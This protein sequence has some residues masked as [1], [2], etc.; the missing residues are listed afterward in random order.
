MLL[1]PSP[2]MLVLSL[3]LVRRQQTVLRASHTVTSSIQEMYDGLVRMAE[4]G[5]GVAWADLSS[6]SLHDV[7]VSSLSQSQQALFDS[8]LVHS[9][10]AHRGAAGSQRN[11]PSIASSLGI[12]S[13]ITETEVS[14]NSGGTNFPAPRNSKCAIAHPLFE[15]KSKPDITVPSPQPD[16]VQSSRLMRTVSPVQLRKS[17]TSVPQKLVPRGDGSSVVTYNTRLNTVLNSSSTVKS[18]LIASTGNRNFVSSTCTSSSSQKSDLQSYTLP[19][20][21]PKTSPKARDG[22]HSDDKLVTSTSATLP[23]PVDTHDGPHFT[24]LRPPSYI[25]PPEFSRTAFNVFDDNFVSPAR[26]HFSKQG[27]PK[28]PVSVLQQPFVKQ[29]P[30]LQNLHPNPNNFVPAL[31]QVSPAVLCRPITSP[32][33][34]YGGHSTALGL[35]TPSSF[36]VSQLASSSHA[37]ETF[38]AERSPFDVSRQRPTYQELIMQSRQSRGNLAA[39]FSAVQHSQPSLSGP[40]PALPMAIVTPSPL[41]PSQSHRHLPPPRARIAVS[42]STSHQPSHQPDFHRR[43]NREL[44]DEPDLNSTYTIS[45]ESDKSAPFQ[46]SHARPVSA[47]STASFNPLVVLH[48]NSP[49]AISARH[50][51]VG[52]L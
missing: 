37:A 18:S 41:R 52:K 48:A 26:P 3:E 43:D 7:S 9:S 25:P 47:F 28:T 24:P 42:T 35:P 46:S 40:N 29:S 6:D 20:P 11:S 19:R 14:A 50:R 15:A 16:I 4:G 12:L 31:H 5:K 33:P 2:R 32:L 1:V 38:R 44:S 36:R 13:S 45:D 21:S 51:A 17:G 49:K 22:F 23:H 30:S 8:F 34:S 27:L 39:P 10:P